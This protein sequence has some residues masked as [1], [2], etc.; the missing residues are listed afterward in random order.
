MQRTRGE[1]RY[2]TDED[3]AQPFVYSKAQDALHLCERHT[4]E[5]PKKTKQ[6]K[7]ETLKIQNAQTRRR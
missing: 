4:E 5:H 1:R 3:T 7:T 2:G 6:N